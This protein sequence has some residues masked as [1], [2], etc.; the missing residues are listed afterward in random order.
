VYE[1]DEAA[2][3]EIDDDPEALDEL[4]GLWNGLRVR[5]GIHTGDAGI[6][7]DEVTKG[8]DYYGPMV[9]AAAR[10]EATACGGQIHATA[11]TIRALSDPNP[12]AVTFAA[13]GAR[14]LR[15]VSDPMELYQ[16]IPKSLCNRTFVSGKA[17]KADLY[18]GDDNGSM[19]KVQS[20]TLKRGGV[21]GNAS[22]PP[23]SGDISDDTMS[24]ASRLSSQ[25]RGLKGAA[26]DGPEVELFVLS[27]ALALRMFPKRQQLDMARSMATA[28]RL[29][30]AELTRCSTPE[31]YL[32][33][34]GRRVA[35]RVQKAVQV[36]F[37]QQQAQ[38]GPRHVATKDPIRSTPSHSTPLGDGVI[39][40]APDIL[41]GSVHSNVDAT[42]TAYPGAIDVGPV[43]V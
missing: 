35:T 26:D 13:I 1:A 10:V 40:Q 22:V 2:L 4:H 25:S 14:E 6:V 33:F 27:A 29:P 8:Y 20:G 39:V 41:C 9:N 21:S 17:K 16:V 28:W 30:A 11:A 38:P 19:R 23:G 34:V 32:T 18:I 36:V 3:D 42:G 12:A 5:T 24:R 37:Q 7:F 43:D 15:G 31:D